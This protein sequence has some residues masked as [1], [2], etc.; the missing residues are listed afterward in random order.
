MKVEAT[1]SPGGFR[2]RNAHGDSVSVRDSVDGE[3]NSPRDKEVVVLMVA[4]PEYDSVVDSKF[5]GDV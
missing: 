1:L 3:A 4:L 5:D 2:G